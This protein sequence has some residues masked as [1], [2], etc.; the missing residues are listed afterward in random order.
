MAG[1][2]GAL[3]ALVLGAF[4]GASVWRLTVAAVVASPLLALMTGRDEHRLGWWSAGCHSTVA[5]TLGHLAWAELDAGSLGLAGLMG[6]G[7]Y[8]GARAQQRPSA[9][10]SCLLLSTWGVLMCA[11][12]MARQPI[13]AAAV[14]MAALSERVP[15]PEHVSKQGIPAWVF[16]VRPAWLVSMLLGALALPYWG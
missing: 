13:L 12:V 3:V 15:L 16:R 9:A 10:A 5:W 8:A 4:L 11:L 14:A 2:G 6:L 7:L 1:L